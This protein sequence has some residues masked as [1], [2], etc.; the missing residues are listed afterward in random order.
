M[1]TR[2]LHEV[3]GEKSPDSNVGQQQQ[4]QS[5]SPVQQPQSIVNQIH[6][7]E[8]MTIKE[9]P[10]SSVTSSSPVTSITSHEAVQSQASAHPTAVI[11]TRQRMITTQGQIRYTFKYLKFF[12]K[13]SMQ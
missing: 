5:Q 10:T 2:E 12:K 3:K 7:Q 8:G 1:E 11:A 9:I 4:A 13:L 6:L